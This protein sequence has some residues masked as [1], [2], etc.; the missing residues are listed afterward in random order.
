MEL[1]LKE[2][3]DRADEQAARVS[4]SAADDR[5][6]M[7]NV[8]ARFD[9]ESWAHISAV[10]DPLAR[11]RPPGTHTG[12]DPLPDSETD[13][14]GR[15]TRSHPQR[16]GEALVELARRHLE[17]A[18]LPSSGGHR[19]H[20]ALTI[21]Y[22][23]LRD[24]VGAGLVDTGES[25]PVS[26]VRRLACDTHLS[27]VITDPYG[28]PLD[29][30][31]TARLFPTHIRRALVIRDR[32]CAFPGC[33][34]PPAWCDA[35]HIV[36]WIDGGHTSL[37]NG[38]LLCR[39]HHRVIHRNEWTVALDADGRPRFTPPSWIDPTRQPRLNRS[40]LRM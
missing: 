2:Q 18:T 4:L 38:V 24:Q 19:S 28:Y 15:D 5:H 10:L 16:M 25:L 36:H 8:R 13:G 12:P 23:T 14:T 27:T 32:G 37:A 9:L 34:R 6:G 1:R 26:A 17:T 20:L 29:V 40:H 11:P 30:G 31:R 35:H 39:H 3:L 33:T 7:I 22:D 21:D